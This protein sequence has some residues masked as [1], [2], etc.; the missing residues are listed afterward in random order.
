LD[1]PT[2]AG[3]LLP[4]TRLFVAYDLDA[5]GDKGASRLKAAT[6]RAQQL[7]VPKLKERDKDI[8][9]YYQSGGDLRRWVSEATGVNDDAEALETALLAW[10][11][12]H[13][14]EPTYSPGGHIVM[15]RH[16]SHVNDA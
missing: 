8:T 2:W 12:C 10:G 1:V 5:A 14:Y 6:G 13:E 9:D 11:E 16:D 4:I 7:A 15:R 3:Y